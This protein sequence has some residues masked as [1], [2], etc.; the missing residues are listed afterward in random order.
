MKNISPELKNHLSREVTTL[1]TCWKITRKDNS[2]KAFTNLD[3]DIEFESVVYTSI[4][5]FNPTS[6]ETKDNLSVDNLDV[7]GV[8]NNDFITAP[9]L[10]AGLYD[11]AE[12]E[13]FFINYE[14]LPQG[15]LQLKKGTLGEVKLKG[16]NFTAEIRGLAESLQQNIGELYS[17]SCRA[18]LGD[19]RCKVDLSSFKVSAS[20]TEI[21]DNNSFRASVL[22]QANGYF[23]GGEIK[24]T[25]GSNINLRM[26]VKEFSESVISLALSFPYQIQIGDN[27]EALAGCDKTV[28][29]CKSK[30][31]NI[32][33]FRGEPHIP[34]TDQI[35]KTG[36]SI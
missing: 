4:T 6:I 22:T 20:V 1:A 10:L 24:F 14:D 13:I 34:G 12:V 33:N 21:I 23:T 16:N 30:F 17:A 18:I 2:V 5:G 31:D 35:S 8:L 27:F 36:G 26:E 32:I 29:T 28:S 9:D 7:D 15:K 19:N 25:S 3:K 11:F